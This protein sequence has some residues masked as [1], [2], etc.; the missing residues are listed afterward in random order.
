MFVFL[1]TNWKT[2][3]YYYRVYTLYNWY[4]VWNWKTKG[5]L[6]TDTVYVESAVLMII[7][8]QR[9]IP[10]LRGNDALSPVKQQTWACKYHA[11]SLYCVP[12][13]HI[14]SWIT[15]ESNTVNVSSLNSN[16]WWIHH[17]NIVSVRHHGWWKK[18]VIHMYKLLTQG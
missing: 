12:F 2:V 15:S 14:K 13:I 8:S 6:L 18:S 16:I 5:L 7:I 3:N 10:S 11:E 17:S 9:L 4:V 1:Y